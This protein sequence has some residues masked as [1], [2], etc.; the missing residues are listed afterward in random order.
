MLTHISEWFKEA[1]IEFYITRPKFKV[2]ELFKR[3]GLYD[4]LGEDHIFSRRRDALA[5]I[6][7]KYGDLINLESLRNYLPVDKENSSGII[8]V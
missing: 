1:G 2:V 8:S 7:H 5:S 4:K 3:T 6:E